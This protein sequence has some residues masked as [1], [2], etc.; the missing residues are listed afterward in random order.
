MFSG[1]HISLNCSFLSNIPV[2]CEK[3]ED[4]DVGMLL[5]KVISGSSVCQTGVQQT[6]AATACVGDGDMFL[7][8]KKKTTEY[9]QA[10]PLILLTH[11]G[12]KEKEKE[13]TPTDFSPPGATGLYSTVLT[14][15]KTRWGFFFLV[16]RC[17]RVT[18][19]SV[20]DT[21][22]M[23]HNEQVVEKQTNKQNSRFLHGSGRVPNV[24]QSKSQ[25]TVW[26]SQLLTHSLPA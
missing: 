25:D 22:R 6:A 16:S 11:A 1:Q 18:V 12:P 19:I 21:D 23:T 9:Q 2:L 13:R 10:S 20:L 3:A 17:F 24:F 5:Q 15:A 14:R 8:K 26:P 4:R 7:T